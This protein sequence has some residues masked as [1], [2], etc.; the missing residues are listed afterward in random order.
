VSHSLR[1]SRPFLVAAIVP[2]V[3][4][5]TL[6]TFAWPNAR[7]EPRQL[8]L[9]LAGSAAATAPAARE[10]SSQPGAFDLHRYA[11]EKEARNAVEHRDVY[12]ALVVSRGGRTLLTATGG[13]PLVAGMLEH[14]LAPAGSAVRVVDVAPADPD[15]PRG[16]VFG[17]LVFP[18]V[19]SS[20]VA[21]VFVSGVA[22]P[23]LK[24]VGALV[25]AAIVAGLTATTLVQTWLGVIGGDWLVNA[26][27]LSLTM[28]AVASFIAGLTSLLG[29]AGTALGAVLMVMIGN[30]WSGISSAPELL[31]KPIGIT[32]Q[33]LPPGAGGNLLRSS[34]FFDRA[35]SAGHL[36][37]LLAW[38][39]IGLAL[40]WIAS[41][42]QRRRSAGQLQCLETEPSANARA[43]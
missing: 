5:F 2:L 1:T 19:L 6:S 22:R 9:G 4:A 43:A 11:S 28:L 29:Q 41:R 24:Q 39:A 37:V 3:L 23:G 26:A 33:L 10:L 20:I 15:D 7:L 35:G 38:T 40:I 32:G 34:G 17:S 21:A 36:T 16:S 27:I 30:P 8:P 25:V 14:A 18:L 42:V 13:S 31:P 12:G